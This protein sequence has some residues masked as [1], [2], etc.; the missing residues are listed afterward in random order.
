VEFLGYYILFHIRNEPPL[1]KPQGGDSLL[2]QFARSFREEVKKASPPF[3]K[4]SELKV[5]EEGVVLFLRFSE[6]MISM[7]GSLQGVGEASN[8]ELW[9]RSV[10]YLVSSLLEYHFGEGAVEGMEDRRG[11]LSDLEIIQCDNVSGVGAGVSKVPALTNGSISSLNPQATAFVSSFTSGN[12]SINGISSNFTVQPKPQ[13]PA[14]SFS[15]FGVNP[16]SRPNA[17]GMP[18]PFSQPT[19][20]L[21][22]P[23][24]FG[25][26]TSTSTNP[27]PPAN[28]F[29]STSSTSSTFEFGKPP[30]TQHFGSG[31]SLANAFAGGSGS[32]SFGFGKGS[33]F[34][35]S[36]TAATSTKPTQKPDMQQH[37]QASQHQQTHSDQPELKRTE[38]PNPF[39]AAPTPVPP[40]SL[41]PS[42]TNS[43]PS[44]S[45]PFSLTPSSTPPPK[46]PVAVG[47]PQA[48]AF[49]KFAPFS[50]PSG[51]AQKKDETTTSI[52]N[53]WPVPAQIT[54]FDSV[55]SR[56]ADGPVGLKQLI[57]SSSASNSATGPKKASTTTPLPFVISQPQI[58]TQ[59]QAP[60]P[61][62]IKGWV[63]EFSQKE[64][65]HLFQSAFAA[66]LADTLAKVSYERKVRRELKCCFDRWLKLATDRCEKKMKKVERERKRAEE[67]HANQKKSHM[68]G[69]TSGISRLKRSRMGSMLISRGV[70]EVKSSG[71]RQVKRKLDTSPAKGAAEIG[72]EVKKV[73]RTAI[74]CCSLLKCVFSDQRAEYQQKHWESG[75]FIESIKEEVAMQM[76]VRG[77][78]ALPPSWSVILS[79]NTINPTSAG[80]LR[81]K[82]GLEYD[83]NGHDEEPITIMLEDGTRIE[84]HP[85]LI[86]F[87]CSYLD[88]S[89]SSE[90]RYN[91]W[92]DHTSIV[93][94][95]I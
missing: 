52:T 91:H 95:E 57:S 19:S 32:S 47:A 78:P 43:R 40:F 18:N 37:F 55:T 20:T 5:T 48:P 81:V 64:F 25:I 35:G 86:V 67:W 87:E 58:K 56:G 34:G 4:R 54:T 77:C 75:T 60:K 84:E 30:Q 49:P 51:G 94:Q 44:S 17:F 24:A 28:A 62:P 7:H 42:V 2:L 71:W 65:Q 16:F 80:W 38:V 45:L 3:A 79:T 59:V 76:T 68:N 10:V 46:G 83:A 14:A 69:T 89:A 6:Q 1:P 90:A 11:G 85:G 36:F 33:A 12:T 74:P 21:S 61:D 88:Q 31:S 41:A 82:F 63:T 26:V 93:S 9:R 92:L 8:S 27:Q 66:M 13:T 50:T 15:S 22:Q 53:N 29:G 70:G 23:N 73:C 39:G 72:E